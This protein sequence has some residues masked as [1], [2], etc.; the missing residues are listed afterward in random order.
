MLGWSW[1]INYSYSW[2]FVRNVLLKALAL[3][4]MLNVLYIA[5][6]PLPWLSRIT[7]YNVVFPGRERLPFSQNSDDAYSISVQRLEGMFASHVIQ[8]NKADDEFR[9][10]LLGDSSVWGWLL[11]PDETLSACLNAQDYRTTSGQRVVVYNLGYPVLSAFK[12]MLIL[13]AGLTHKPDAVVWVFTLQSLL[14]FEQLRHPITGN[15]PDRALN[16][17]DTYDLNLDRDQLNDDA[18]LL[19]SSI[20]GQRRELADLLRHQVYGLAWWLTGIDHTN[21]IFYEA[22]ADNLLAA[23]NLLGAP[24][25]QEMILAWDVVRGVQAMTQQ[26]DVP[27][28][29]VNGPIYRATGQN[30]DIRYN[31]YFPRRAYDEYRS[32]LGTLAEAEGW[33]VWDAWE[34]VPNDQFTD[35]PFHYTP[36]ATCDFAAQLGPRI[37][38]LAAP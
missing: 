27:L 21:P 6:D 1:L 32:Q 29:I 16:L 5:L 18:T 4:V 31:N 3:F 38:E 28:L 15:N 25:G 26:A 13:E 7:F 20:V 30:S 22:R 35:T 36:T 11:E 23:D 17:I 37:I 24:D 19:E 8:E 10:L 2:G 33:R 14:D 34:A 9:V 12:D